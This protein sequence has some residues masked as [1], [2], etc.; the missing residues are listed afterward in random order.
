MCQK[1]EILIVCC[2]ERCSSVYNNGLRKPQMR[3]I[4]HPETAF[5]LCGKATDMNY[6][7]DRFFMDLPIMSSVP[8]SCPD[9][10]VNYKFQLVLSQVASKH[11]ME[12]ETNSRV[13]CRLCSGKKKPQ[14]VSMSDKKSTVQSMA[15][16]GQAHVEAKWT[17]CAEDKC[18][19]NA[20]CECQ[21]AALLS[22]DS[23][24]AKEGE[25]CILAG[26]GDFDLDDQIP[27]ADA[28]PTYPLEDLGLNQTYPWELFRINS[29]ERFNDGG[30]LISSRHYYSI[31]EIAK[32]GSVD[33]RIHDGGNGTALVPLFNNDNSRGRSGVNQTVLAGTSEDTLTERISAEKTCFE[34]NAAFSVSV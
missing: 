20:E 9:L 26:D 12:L 27:L 23:D 2:E 8:T 32:D 31:F 18:N 13:Q 33:A 4:P 3:L 24:W 7:S 1:V 15:P 21:A 19:P 30:F 6:R 25:A 17:C 5:V 10:L 14:I 16:A 34:T 11:I 28:A 22:R 29:I